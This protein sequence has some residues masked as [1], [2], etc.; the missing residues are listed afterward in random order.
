[1]MR[2]EPASTWANTW[3]IPT[4]YNG[5][6]VHLTATMRGTY[7][8]HY[9]EES[10]VSQIETENAVMVRQ[11]TG[12]YV[13]LADAVVYNMAGVCVSTVSKGDVIRLPDG[14]YVIGAGA[15]TQKIVIK[16]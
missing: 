13:S 9:A 16:H 8:H 1:M 10:S 6:T 7:T 4:S 3:R 2:V 15:R 5:K 14:I 11:G 12:D